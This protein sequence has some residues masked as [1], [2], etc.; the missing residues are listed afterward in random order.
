METPAIET[1]AEQT[2]FPHKTEH[3]E[4]MVVG[5]QIGGRTSVAPKSA[6]NLTRDSSVE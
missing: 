4:G 3:P 6:T 1:C 5:L 2:S